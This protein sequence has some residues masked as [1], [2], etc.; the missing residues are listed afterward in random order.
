MHPAI[1][2][3]RARSLYDATAHASEAT[4]VRVFNGRNEAAEADGIATVD[5]VEIVA[6]APTVG[7]AVTVVD[8]DDLSP[9]EVAAVAARQ[10]MADING[11]IR[12]GRTDMVMLRRVARN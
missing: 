11:V 2:A 12:A 1:P 6:D 4:R 9:A 8:A 10:A 5:A 3:P 7:V